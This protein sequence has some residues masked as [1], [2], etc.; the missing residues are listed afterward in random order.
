VRKLN[1]GCHSI[2]L[3]DRLIIISEKV[4][5]MGGGGFGCYL[6]QRRALESTV[7]KFGFCYQRVSTFIEIWVSSRLILSLIN[8]TLKCD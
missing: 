6:V 3:Y 4:I 8:Q 2:R 5:K 7:L 1:L